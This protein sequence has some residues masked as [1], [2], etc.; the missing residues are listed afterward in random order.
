M[1]KIKDWIRAELGPARP[2][3]ATPVAIMVYRVSMVFCMVLASSVV[4]GANNSL[5]DQFDGYSMTTIKSIIG[6]MAVGGLSGMLQ[7]LKTERYAFDEIKHPT[8]FFLS[9]L[10]G[11]L[12]GGFVSVQA[13]E[14]AGMPGSLFG[15]TIVI[16]SFA[17]VAT[18]DFAWQELTRRF[19]KDGVA[20]RSLLS[21]EPMTPAPPATK[22]P[23]KANDDKPE[24]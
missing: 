20:A 4:M 5:G 12:V 21:E 6:C 16:G 10:S 13:G 3:A 2:D 19:S 9:N 23:P 15:L 22:P 7:R 18:V 14:G 11:T 1:S 8:T 24:P 17:G